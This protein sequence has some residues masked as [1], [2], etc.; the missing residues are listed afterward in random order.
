MYNTRWLST[1]PS[2]WCRISEDLCAT[3]GGTDGIDDDVDKDDDD[4]DDEHTTF[5]RTC[6]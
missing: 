3:S 5:E 1:R 6:S 2:Q 4:V